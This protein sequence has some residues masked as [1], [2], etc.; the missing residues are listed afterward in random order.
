L[1]PKRKIGRRT[2]RETLSD[3]KWI[4]DIRVDIPVEALMEYLELRD[5]LSNVVLDKGANDKHIWRLSAS[6]DYTAK[7]AYDLFFKGAI[8]F[9]PYERI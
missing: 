1:V 9:R 3:E 7:S 2:V 8:Y 5:I 6:G 4:D